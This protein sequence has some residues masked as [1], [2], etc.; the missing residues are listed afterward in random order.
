MRDRS[1]K[2]MHVAAVVLMVV[3]TMA[4]AVMPMVYRP[5]ALYTI[6]VAFCTDPCKTFMQSCPR[7]FRSRLANRDALKIVQD[8][9]QFLLVDRTA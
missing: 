3:V 6:S 4:S 2:I 8:T 7:V 1:W 9:T 5:V